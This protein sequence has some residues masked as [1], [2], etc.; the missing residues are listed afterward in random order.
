MC[1]HRG[2]PWPNLV[3]GGAPSVI[4]VV[5]TRPVAKDHPVTD[6]EPAI[7]PRFHHRHVIVHPH[8]AAQ[9]LERPSVEEGGGFLPR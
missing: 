2:I 7:K 3:I 6:A 8:A 1:G 4:R 9:G 5:I